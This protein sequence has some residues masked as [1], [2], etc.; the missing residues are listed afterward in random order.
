M[1][2]VN[3]KEARGNF[4]SL[5]DRVERGEEIIIKRRGKK[6][7][8]LISPEN[9]K[10]LPSLQNFRAAI[11]LTGDPLSKTVTDLRNEERF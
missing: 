5:L 2:E 9:N 8:R 1:M 4:S 11:K 6:I 10:F 3:V 7:A